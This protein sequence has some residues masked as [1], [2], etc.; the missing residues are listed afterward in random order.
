MARH[1]WSRDALACG[2]LDLGLPVTA[3]GVVSDES[4]LV[5]EYV[6]RS[7]AEAREEF[8][9][10]IN[11]NPSVHRTPQEVVELGLW[12]RLK[13]TVPV[14]NSWA[15]AMAVGAR[16]Q[17]VGRTV[18]LMG[19]YLDVVADKAKTTSGQD[20]LDWYA[21]RAALMGAYAACE[22]HMLTDYTEDCEATREFLRDRVVGDGGALFAKTAGLADVVKTLLAG[23][24]AGGKTGVDMGSEVFKSFLNPSELFS[25]LA[26]TAASSVLGGMFKPAGEDH[27][28]KTQAEQSTTPPSASSS[29][30]N[31]TS[32]LAL[33]E[34][35]SLFGLVSYD[36]KEAKDLL[37]RFNP[38]FSVIAWPLDKEVPHVIDAK[39]H[40]H[41]VRLIHDE[42]GIVV[43]VLRV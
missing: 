40:L 26:T 1:G 18:E 22:L 37:E 23:A 2:A 4:E 27:A 41:V 11:A 38:T 32:E 34:G 42:Q 19:E 28:L 12:T 3:H 5:F 33:P 14:R 21:T 10:A 35:M 16:P 25:N 15:Q 9:E 30:D 39:A 17:N 6:K 7:N 43:D 13:R 31:V 29:S 24:G 20:Q 36:V 8:V